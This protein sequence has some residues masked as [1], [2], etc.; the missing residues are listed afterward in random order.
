MATASIEAY[1]RTPTGLRFKTPQGLSKEIRVYAPGV[2]RVTVLMAGSKPKTRELVVVREPVTTG[3]TVSAD[4]AGI[5]RAP[6]GQA[7]ASPPS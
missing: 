6:P 5:A 2:L 1:E 7:H 4:A 3:F